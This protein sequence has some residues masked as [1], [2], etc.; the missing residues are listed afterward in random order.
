MSAEVTLPPTLRHLEGHDN[1]KMEMVVVVPVA[2]C[3][4]HLGIKLLKWMRA[5]SPEVLHNCIILG[6]PKLSDG[7]FAALREAAGGIPDEHRPKFE[8]KGYF[9]GANQIGRAHV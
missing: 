7:E 3:E 6:A 9:S 4:W 1:R 2:R 8:D 5:L